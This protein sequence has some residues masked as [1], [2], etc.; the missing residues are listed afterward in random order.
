MGQLFSKRMEP[1]E[2]IYFCTFL[3]LQMS[4]LI[5]DT[6]LHRLWDLTVH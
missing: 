3:T 2:E 6:K 1:V 4:P 5:L